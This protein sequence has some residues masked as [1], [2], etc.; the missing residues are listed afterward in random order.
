MAIAFDTA[1][2][3]YSGSGSS[4]TQSIVVSGTSDFAIG[5]AMVPIARSMTSLAWNGTNMTQVA[6]V[7]ASFFKLYAYYLTGIST[8]TANLVGTA[9]SSTEIYMGAIFYSGASQSGQPDASNTANGT[10]TSI[11]QTVTTI[12]DNA[13]TACCTLAD[14]GGLA[15][16]TGSTLRDAIQNGAWGIFDSN[17]AKTPAGSTSMVQT[18]NSGNRA[19]IIVSFSPAGSA[20]TAT[21]TRMLMGIGS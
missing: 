15:A 2:T 18:M 1:K 9:D 20:S 13:W 3:K 11:T 16:S 17:T 19:G 12:S 5:F 10:G 14:V 8:G 6:T 4:S 21:P 7:N